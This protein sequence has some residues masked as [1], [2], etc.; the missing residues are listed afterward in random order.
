[1]L[2]IVPENGSMRAEGIRRG[3]V[4]AL[5]ARS[6]D[7]TVQRLPWWGRTGVVLPVALGLQLPACTGYEGVEDILVPTAPTAPRVTAEWSEV[8]S[9]APGPEVTD[10]TMRRKI[11]VSGH[12]WKVR[13]RASGIEMV[14]VMPGEF[15]MGSPE[16]EPDRNAN[17]GPQHRVRLT[18]P[19]YLGATEVTQA[20]WRRV[21]GSSQ[22]FFPGDDKPA[23]GSWDV[24]QAF[25]SKAN[26]DIPAGVNPL[27]A[28]TE[29]EW[30]YACRAGTTGPFSFEGPVGHDVLNY[31]DGVVKS[32]YVDGKLKV[33]D[34][35]LVVEWET[36][37]SPGCRMSTAVAGSLPPNAWGLHEMHGNLR[38]WTEDKYWSEAYASREGIAV[39]PF[40]PAAGDDA[41]TLRGG[42][43][44]KSERYSRSAHREAGGVHTGSNRLGFRVARTL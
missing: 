26:A 43:W 35:K 25:L 18:K 31:N 12:P 42:D 29:A 5:S 17:E 34:G 22:G 44:Y 19:F 21:T 7:T 11:E 8:V 41:R 16:S 10:A 3:S 9:Q 27:R 37:P 13:D 24:F 38:E 1:M 30:E 39:D 4:D 28:P 23:D 2:S 20:Q 33:V 6:N 40:V 36:P 32:P 15:L 14:L